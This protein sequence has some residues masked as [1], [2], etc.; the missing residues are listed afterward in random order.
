MFPPA[1][2]RLSITTGCPRPSESRVATMRAM[3]SLAPPGAK[4]RTN[5]IGLAGY[6]AAW[7]AGTASSASA[8]ADSIRQLSFSDMEVSPGM[9]LQLEQKTAN[10][11]DLQD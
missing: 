6:S 9:V 5:R 1:P 4:P 8:A 2:G 7:S 11:Q 10:G 3:V